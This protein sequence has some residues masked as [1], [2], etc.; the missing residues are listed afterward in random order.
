MKV[1]IL[2]VNQSDAKQKPSNGNY[3]I[4][5]GI[6][7]CSVSDTCSLIQL[8]N[9]HTHLILSAHHFSVIQMLVIK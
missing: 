2:G 3:K 9:I 8:C 4:S 6:T 5:H 7:I 1:A